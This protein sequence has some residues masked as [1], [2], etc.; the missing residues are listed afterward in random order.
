[1]A[2]PPALLVAC[3]L[4]LSPGPAAAGEF[5]DTIVRLV[6][7]SAREFRSLRGQVE[8]EE[9]SSGDHV[10]V[11]AEPL[12][13]ATSCEVRALY[14]PGEPRRPHVY[15]CTWKY[16]DAGSSA[17]SMDA[18]ARELFRGI[19]GC[20]GRVRLSNPLEH[21][22]GGL[23]TLGTDVAADGASSV[24]FMVMGGVFG[25]LGGKVTLQVKTR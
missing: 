22:G 23:L 7:D 4:G 3:A 19:Q 21:R 10:F 9:A 5:C 1:M 2:R 13:G 24:R 8:R 14:A 12:P 16:R 25:A 20:A 11:E 6:G 17:G 18:K 15:Q